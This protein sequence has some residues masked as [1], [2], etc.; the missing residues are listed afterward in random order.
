M[1]EILHHCT[2][3]SRNSTTLWVLMVRDSPHVR[4][5]STP[6]CKQ[7]TQN[8]G[9]M[10][11]TKKCE[12]ARTSTPLILSRCIALSMSYLTYKKYRAIAFGIISQHNSEFYVQGVLD[13]RPGSRS[14]K[15]RQTPHRMMVTTRRK[16]TNAHRGP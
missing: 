5:L 8:W 13:C 2:L 10:P 15:R 7:H 16:G 3:Y 11:Y 12:S 6:K 14:L 1:E 9:W 4:H